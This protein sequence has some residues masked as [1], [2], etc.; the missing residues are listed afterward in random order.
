MPNWNL[1]VKDFDKGSPASKSGLTRHSPF[2][3]DCSLVGMIFGRHGRKAPCLV[4]KQRK[5]HC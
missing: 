2:L 3:K 1:E 5:S 4:E